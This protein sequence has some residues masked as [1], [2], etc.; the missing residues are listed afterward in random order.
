ME[1]K[2]AV[3]LGAD[4]SIGIAAAIN[5]IYDRAEPLNKLKK[6]VVDILS[7]DDFRANPCISRRAAERA[8]IPWPQSEATKFEW[9]VE[10]G[11]GLD[12]VLNVI[13]IHAMSSICLITANVASGTFH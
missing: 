13:L 12:A 10:F 4:V 3:N 1:V 11:N 7:F 6:G 8:V 2:H 9:V 5:S